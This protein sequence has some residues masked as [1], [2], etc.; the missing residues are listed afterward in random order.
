VRLRQCPTIRQ[1]M[2]AG[3]FVSALGKGS[4]GGVRVRSL[5][6][7]NP[8][9]A[10]G[11]NALTGRTFRGICLPPRRRRL[12][13]FRLRS[14][15]QSPSNCTLS[16]RVPGVFVQRK[17]SGGVGNDFTAAP[18]ASIDARPNGRFSGPILLVELR[19]DADFHV[20]ATL[21]ECHGSP[22]FVDD[23]EARCRR[24]LEDIGRD[25]GCRSSRRSRRRS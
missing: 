24:W 15:S 1:R 16:R 2:R 13:R 17:R 18:A 4:A 9:G 14:D 5:A 25:V 23:L 6:L 21:E 20:V 12:V 11:E 19:T 7:M 10:G 3:N 22:L 8:T